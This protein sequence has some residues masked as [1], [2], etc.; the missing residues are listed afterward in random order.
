MTT[1]TKKESTKATAGA[2]VIP[3]GELAQHAEKARVMRQ[4]RQGSYK[5]NL[6]ALA[7]ALLGHP[8]LYK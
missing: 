4:I 7:G 1:K 3:F 2:Q 6:S 5:P 8:D